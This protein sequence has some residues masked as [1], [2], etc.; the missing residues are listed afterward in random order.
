MKEVQQRQS[1]LGLA[2]WTKPKSPIRDNRCH[3]GGY[4]LSWSDQALSRFRQ[5][6]VLGV[7]FESTLAQ[8]GPI[9]C[10]LI[11]ARVTGCFNGKLRCDKR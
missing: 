1:F 5:K 6:N 2:G 4:H 10:C 8:N 7:S 3:T 9:P 11:Q